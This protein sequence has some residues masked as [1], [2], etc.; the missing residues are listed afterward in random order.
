MVRG[1][2]IGIVYFICPFHLTLSNMD[3]CLGIWRLPESIENSLENIVLLFASKMVMLVLCLCVC[4]LYVKVH[5]NKF[6]RFFFFSSSRMRV[7]FSLRFIHNAVSLPCFSYMFFFSNLILF[8]SCLSLRSFKNL[9]LE[10]KFNL[11]N[12]C[13]FISGFWN[14]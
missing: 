2:R 6:E 1:R 12:R 14:A 7:T 11:A 4:L 9:F 5:K 3:V 13:S 8:C 10:T